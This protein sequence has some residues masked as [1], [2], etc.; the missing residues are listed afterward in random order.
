MK[1]RK[2]DASPRRY[3]RSSDR[4]FRV[5]QP[6]YFSSREGERGP[7]K[8]QEHAQTELTRYIELH[9]F[10]RKSAQQRRV[11]ATPRVAHMR[12]RH[13]YLTPGR[14]A[15]NSS[16]NAAPMSPAVASSGRS[17]LVQMG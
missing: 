13:I 14:Q 7:F 2:T 1:T 3:F 9:T 12:P 16:K 10:V 6:W 11:A 17:L 5:N 8:S 4:I 15:P